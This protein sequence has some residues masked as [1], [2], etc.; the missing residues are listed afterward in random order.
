MDMEKNYEVHTVE[1]DPPQVIDG[2]K[3]KIP[4]EK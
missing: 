2:L 4:L 1:L 3:I